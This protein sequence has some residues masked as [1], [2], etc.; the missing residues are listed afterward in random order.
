MRRMAAYNLSL[1][2][3]KTY[4]RVF[5]WGTKPFIYAAITAITKDAPARVTAA[6]HGM[7]DGWRS[8]IVSVLGMRQINAIN[9]PPKASDFHRATVID[10]DTVDFNDIN[11]C[12][13]STYTSG[14]K[15]QFYT[16]VSLAGCE[17]RLTIRDH[18]GGTALIELTST[19]A[20]GIALDDT[21]KTITVTI[22]AAQTAAF[23]WTA[24]VF[25]L[26]VEDADGNVTLIAQGAVTVDSE[27]TT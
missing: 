9:S 24:G 27:V 13:F 14:G 17:A 19:P 10:A 18:V 21:A 23:T 8:A 7:P 26:E 12:E 6:A 15:L 4:R 22:T 16:P 2:Q 25:D 20:A 1:V 11:A 3:G 5:R